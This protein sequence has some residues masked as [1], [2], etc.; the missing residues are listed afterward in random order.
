V[1][2]TPHVLLLNASPDESEMYGFWLAASGYRVT[3]ARSA[4]FTRHLIETTAV[5]VLVIDALFARPFRRADFERRRDTQR[6]SLGVVVLSGY[7]CDAT[8]PPHKGPHEVRVFK[9]CLPH[10][11]SDYVDG[12]LGVR[13][14]GLFHVGKGNHVD[15]RTASS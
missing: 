1:D 7:P 2:T 9:P 15:H 10:E 13:T 6:T 8:L 11:L 12:L 14:S 4:A 5:D 3:V